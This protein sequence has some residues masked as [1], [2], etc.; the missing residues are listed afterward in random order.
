MAQSVV[1]LWLLVS[2]LEYVLSLLQPSLHGIHYLH[3]A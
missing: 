2:L 3:I 1:Q